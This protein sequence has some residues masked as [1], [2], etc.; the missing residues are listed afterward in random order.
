MHDKNL[1]VDSNGK[2]DKQS[3]PLYAGVRRAGST[4][5]VKEE[6]RTV[7]W[8]R[9]NF[10]LSFWLIRYLKLNSGAS[11]WATFYCIQQYSLEKV[12]RKSWYS[13]MFFYDIFLNTVPELPINVIYV[14]R[15]GL[16]G[17]TFPF[18]KHFFPCHTIR[19]FASKGPDLGWL[20]LN[21]G[22]FVPHFRWLVPIFGRVVPNFGWLVTEFGWLLSNFPKV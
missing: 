20:F 11:D 21:F 2:L 3:C 16:W 17:S 19:R 5:Q 7:E 13:T 8:G 9:N 10:I 6:K 1:W 4:I 14:K 15:V 18:F 22:Q 12:M